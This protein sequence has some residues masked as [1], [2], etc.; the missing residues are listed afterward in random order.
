M[1]EKGGT[2]RYVRKRQSVPESLLDTV[3]SDAFRGRRLPA[4]FP[5][6]TRR[7]FRR[8]VRYACYPSSNMGTPLTGCIGKCIPNDRCGASRV[9]VSSGVIYGVD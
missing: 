7:H 1:P 2:A 3:L 4:L 5:L 8:F 9:V 6:S